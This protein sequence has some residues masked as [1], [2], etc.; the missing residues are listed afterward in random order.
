MILLLL[1]FSRYSFSAASTASTSPGRVCHE[2]QRR[3]CKH[4]I[5]PVLAMR[6][7]SHFFW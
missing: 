4:R 2:Q 6:G 7:L 3:H 1:F 5:G